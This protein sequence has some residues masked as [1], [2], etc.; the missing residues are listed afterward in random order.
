MGLSFQAPKALPIILNPPTRSEQLQ[1]SK[2]HQKDHQSQRDTEIS[3][4]SMPLTTLDE[5]QRNAKESLHLWLSET[6]LNQLLEYNFLDAYRAQAG[7]GRSISDL[8]WDSNHSQSY[9]S[10]CF[11]PDSILPKQTCC[12]FQMELGLLQKTTEELHLSLSNYLGRWHKELSSLRTSLRDELIQSLE[13]LK[14]SLNR[15][16]CSYELLKNKKDNSQSILSNRTWSCWQHTMELVSKFSLVLD[17]SFL[18][19]DDIILD[20]MFPVDN[21]LMQSLLET[22]CQMHITDAKN[23]QAEELDEKIKCHEYCQA[24]LNLIFDSLT[25]H[26]D[27]PS[28]TRKSRNLIL[29]TVNKSTISSQSTSPLSDEEDDEYIVEN[30]NQSLKRRDIKSSSNTNKN[31]IDEQNQLNNFFFEA[32][33]YRLLYRPELVFTFRLN[34]K[35][36][37]SLELGESLIDGLKNFNIAQGTCMRKLMRMH[38]CA[39]CAGETLSRPC[40]GLCSRILLNC[41][42]PLNH[43]NPHWQRFTETIKG[44]ANMFLEKSN[45]RLEKQFEDFPERLVNYYHQLLNTYHNWLQPQCSGIV[46]LYGVFNLIKNNSKNIRQRMK[47]NHEERLKKYKKVFEQIKT[48]MDDITSVWSRSGTALCSESPYLALLNGRHDQCWN[49]TAISSDINN[50][51]KTTIPSSSRKQ[52]TSF[53]P[54]NDLHQSNAIETDD[55]LSASI[56][57]TNYLLNNPSWNSPLQHDKELAFR[58][59]NEILVRASRDL[60]WSVKTLLAETNAYNSLNTKSNSQKDEYLQGVDKLKTNSWV[61]I[62]TSQK[63]E[64]TDVEQYEASRNSHGSHSDM[65][66]SLG[67]LAYGSILGWN[68]QEEEERRLST[69]LRGNNPSLFDT[70]SNPIQEMTKKKNSTDK[71]QPSKVL[72]RNPYIGSG[73]IPGW[74]LYAWTPISS[75]GKDNPYEKPVDSNFP[76]QEINYEGS[77]FHNPKDSLPPSGEYDYPQMFPFVNMNSQGL[78]LPVLRSEENVTQIYSDMVKNSSNVSSIDLLHRSN[79]QQSASNSTSLRKNKNFNEKK[80][81]A[82]TI[83]T[84]KINYYLTVISLSVMFWIS[85]VT[86]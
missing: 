23:I 71:S 82:A 77:G 27:L 81:L 41:L 74:P 13:M 30:E 33:Q 45:L 83:Y 59:A 55:L 32:E 4:I 61:Q 63:P 86:V 6:Q 44:V 7:Q 58:R 14:I 68:A 62:P 84:E 19:Q 1:L 48:T 49:G 18:T 67:A 51:A 28:L 56:A 64:N 2:K 80:N 20:L 16:L 17:Q 29:N 69:N 3:S 85:S 39:L 10:L 66:N 34:R 43:L 75:P 65:T 50:N 42:R 52:R 12:T 76:Q 21:F 5:N 47:R 73:F 11:W 9:Q 78:N 36:I 54:N 70:S 31:I 26:S 35:L 79:N 8:T 60:D 15:T 53:I 72:D 38:H 37:Q 25:G 22:S 57:S 40:P 46:K 24:R